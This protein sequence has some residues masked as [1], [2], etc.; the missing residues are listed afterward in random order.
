MVGLSIDSLTCWR[1]AWCN[2]VFFWSLQYLS[3][4]GV[5]SRNSTL[6]RGQG[7]VTEQDPTR[8]YQI[9]VF[10]NK[11]WS[12]QFSNTFFHLPL[13]KKTSWDI[14]SCQQKNYRGNIIVAFLKHYDNVE[15]CN[16]I[17]FRRMD[18][19]RLLPAKV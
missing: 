16:I 6:M 18:H 15:I 12:A 19:L 9:S 11:A 5:P 17:Q 1:N 8:E 10:N 14:V 4:C 13:K 7:D 2:I 3:T